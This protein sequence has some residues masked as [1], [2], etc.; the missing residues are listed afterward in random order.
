MSE[1]LEPLL[2]IVDA[3]H[4]LRDRDGEIY[5]AD[6][7]L[8]DLATGH[9]VVAS[10]AVETGVRFRDEGP[11][12]LRPA[13]ETAFLAAVA[14]RCAAA[15]Q[16]L[17]AAAIVSYADLRLG[18]AV[19]DTLDAHVGAG[20]GRFRGIRMASPWHADPRL[21]YARAKIEPALLGDASVRRGFARL[22]RMGLVF[23]AWLY[24]TQLGDVVDLAR[25]FPGAAI[26]LDHAGGPLGSGPYEGHRDGVFSAWRASLRRLAACPNV[27]VKVG[28]FGMPLMGFG[29]DRS[30]PRPGAAAYATAWKPYV[31]ATVEAFG[32]D[33]CMLE[34]NFPPDRKSVSYATLWNA[35]KLAT[36]GY[37]P[38]E[39]AALFHDT[40]ARV[41]RI[42]A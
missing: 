8:A 32:A 7:Y 33:R 30:V 15:K 36:A 31:D 24:H 39:R 4:H 38:A 5:L 21:A 3:H 14:Q 23:E 29:F 19:Q 17:V 26:V 10:V 20:G 37:S 16:P 11:E 27:T 41:Y 2:P 42:A 22:A 34:S 12:A 25:A 40:A 1:I 13:G 28:G 18:D 35:L 9:R 6:E